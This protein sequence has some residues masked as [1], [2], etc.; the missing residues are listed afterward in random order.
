MYEKYEL[1]QLERKVS[2]YK[3]CKATGL[4]PSMFTAWKQ[5]TTTPKRDSL[6]KICDYFEVPL[7]YFYDERTNIDNLMNQAE[8][9]GID[10]KQLLSSLAS[11]LPSQN[12][13]RIAS[14]IEQL[15][16]GE[17]KQIENLINFFLSNH[18]Q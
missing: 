2:T 1:L 4:S 5:G 6:Q 17:R 15:T 7:S 14:D 18:K 16:E 11:A 3:V 10:T 12:A 9:V 8:Q 13:I